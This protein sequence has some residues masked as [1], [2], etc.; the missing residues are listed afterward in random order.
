MRRGSSTGL[1]N[2]AIMRVLIDIDDKDDRTLV[3]VIFDLQNHSGHLQVHLRRMLLC[4]EDADKEKAR[5]AKMETA[6]GV[7]ETEDTSN[8]QGGC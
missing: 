8:R 4:I 1:Q 3:R 5:D 7:V 6:A 2:A